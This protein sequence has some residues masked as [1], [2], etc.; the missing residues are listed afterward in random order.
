MPTT[1]SSYTIFL[2]QALFSGSVMLFCMIMLGFDKSTNIYLPILTGVTTLWLPAPR[3]NTNNISTLPVTNLTSN[4]SSIENTTAL[5]KIPPLLHN[6]TI[7]KNTT[8]PLAD[9]L[10]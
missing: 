1:T 9:Q 8:S 3:L 10:V 6:L 2:T 5:T 7:N 4:N